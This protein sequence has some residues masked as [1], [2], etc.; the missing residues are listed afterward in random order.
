MEE[1]QPLNS[2][3]KILL[4]EFGDSLAK[5]LVEL[6]QSKRPDRGAV[7]L[8]QTARFMAVQHSLKTGYLLTLDPFF[9]GVREVSLTDE[10]IGGGRLTALQ[11]GL[12]EQSTNRRDLFLRK[13]VIRRLPI[14]LWRQAG[15]GPGSC[16]E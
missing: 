12:L 13:N 9:E 7:I 1:E 8:L 11:E 14:R 16:C 2:S 4:H 15:Q 3:E 10:E 5:S 6:L